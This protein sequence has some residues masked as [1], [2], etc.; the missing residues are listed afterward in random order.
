[1]YYYYLV[2]RYNQSVIT[3]C[4]SRPPCSSHFFELSTGNCSQPPWDRV[5]ELS[6]G[7]YSQPPSG[8][9][10]ELSTGNCFRPPR[11]GSGAQIGTDPED[12]CELSAESWTQPSAWGKSFGLSCEPSTG[13]CF[14]PSMATV[15]GHAPNP[16]P[17]PRRSCP[18]GM[19]HRGCFWQPS[20]L[21]GSPQ[22]CRTWPLH[23]REH[24]ATTSGS[25]FDFFSVV[26]HQPE[27]QPF[28]CCRQ[29]FY[30]FRQFIMDFTMTNPYL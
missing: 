25:T 27:T 7:S 6:A 18:R 21:R 29:N 24:P 4:Q 13:N 15:S 2:L 3:R 30:C 1:M 19:D 11:I 16:G 23:L 26:G 12:P 17:W 28:F 5:S 10:F 14:R 20:A 22:C 8:S 9:F